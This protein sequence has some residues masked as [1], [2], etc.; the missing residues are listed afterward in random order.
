MIEVVTGLR[1]RR[2]DASERNQ[3]PGLL[4]L[5]PSSPY[6]SV[7]LPWRFLPGWFYLDDEPSIYFVN[8][9]GR[10]EHQIQVVIVPCTPDTMKV[11]RARPRARFMARGTL[12]INLGF[13]FLNDRF[14]R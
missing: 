10:S 11:H 1:R 4:R 5:T 12:K 9:P 7:A 14:Y 3:I 13:Y 2:C 6:F 8:S